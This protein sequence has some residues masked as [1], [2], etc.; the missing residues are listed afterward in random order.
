LL[1]AQQSGH[2]ASVGFQLYCQ[3]LEEAIRTTRGEAVSVRVDPELR[4]E[5]QGHIPE[6]YV[7]SDAQRLEI[8]QRLATLADMAELH[9][10]GQELRDRFGAL[11]DTVQR[12]LDVVE[13]KILARQLALEQVEQ[14][15]DTITLVFHA[16]TSVQPDVLLRWLQANA[17]GFQFQSEHAVRLSCPAS[18]PELRLAQLKKHLQQLLPGGSI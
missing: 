5:V 18:P 15:H 9:V 2:I 13:L 16:Q 7:A 4:L 8:Y 12:L 3:M 14:R 6:T 1:G 10:I 11:P 17:A